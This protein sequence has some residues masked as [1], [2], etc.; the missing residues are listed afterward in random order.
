ME[1]IRGTV[2]GL[3]AMTAMAILTRGV[4][5]DGDPKISVISVAVMAVSNI[6]GDIIGAV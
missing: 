6:A 5:I 3:P 2:P 1:Y 4:M